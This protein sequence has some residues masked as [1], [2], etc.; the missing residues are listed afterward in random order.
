MPA[1]VGRRTIRAAALLAVASL[2]ALGATACQPA[3]STAKDKPILLIH[4][5]A[6][7]GATNCG[8]TFDTMIGRLK[9]QGFT[10][11]FVKVG[12]YTGDT[13][14][15]MTLRS[16]GDFDNGSSWK[17]VAKAFS[18][19]VYETYTKNGKSVDVVGYS[20]GGLIA[21]GA[22]YGAEGGQSGFSAPIKVE[23]V[24]TLGAPHSGAAWYTNGCLWGQCSTM[25]PGAT[26]IKWLNENGNPQGVGGT[27]WTV[28]GSEADQVTPVDS[29]LYMVVPAAQK[30]RYSD[31][32]HTGDGNWT[33]SQK[34]LDRVV[35]ALAQPGA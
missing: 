8:S 4:G 21:R 30:V 14:C 19:Y 5:W 31:I 24:A 29:G 13:N 10:G 3:R 22:V 16:W 20:M 35:V 34:V 1:L 7:G 33:S 6:T 11:P 25:K 28:F 27:E 12:F 17:D 15:D 32:P 23:D 26:D 2:F 9:A 18:K